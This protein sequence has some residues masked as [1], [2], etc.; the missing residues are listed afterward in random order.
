MTHMDDLPYLGKELLSCFV[1]WIGMSFVLMFLPNTRI[2]FGSAVLGGLLASAAWV[3]LQELFKA[4]NLELLRLSTVYSAFAAIP[5]LLLWIYLSWL[6]FLGGAELSYAYQ[7]A[8]AHAVTAM[9]ASTG[10]PDGVGTLAFSGV[11]LPS[12]SIARYSA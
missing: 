2:R 6:I 5:L 7:N 1:I 3:T 9:G 11:T 10:L 4:G 8:S 12:G